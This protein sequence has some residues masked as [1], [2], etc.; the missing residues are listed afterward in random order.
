M[1]RGGEDLIIF[2]AVD[3]CLTTCHARAE[4]KCAS[5]QS[6]LAETL[7]KSAVRCLEGFRGPSNYLKDL[8]LL[9]RAQALGERE[10]RLEYVDASAG[11]GRV[12]GS[13]PPA[14]TA[15]VR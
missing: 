4:R 15:N 2:S 5:K 10:R 3:C 11:T 13:C 9:A 7:T 14:I 8:D 1:G 12:W 6:T